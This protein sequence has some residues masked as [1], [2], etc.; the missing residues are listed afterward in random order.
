MYPFQ[1]IILP[2]DFSKRCEAIVPAVRAM[3]AKSGANITLFHALDMPPGGY[4]DWYSYA[5][6]VDLQ[7][8]I[9]HTTHSL[10]RFAKRLFEGVPNVETV[11]REGAP[12]AAL[13]IYLKD[14]PADLVMIASHGH[15]AFR[16]MLLGS[17]TS[18]ILHD[19][20]LPVW[21]A[22]HA[23]EDPALHG[24]RNVVCAIDLEPASVKV[25][26]MATR[27]AQDSGATLHVVHSE[28]A[29]EDLTHSDS[30]AR[31]R[32]F[33]EFRAGEDY[34]PLASEAGISA[35]I[36]VVEGPV[37]ESIAGAVTKHNADLLV[38]GRGVVQ[39]TLGRLRSHSNDI[40]RRS[41]CPVLSV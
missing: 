21:T 2:V 3:A 20:N 1:R 9:D 22:A 29:I 5:A 8:V 24:I 35:P 26:M 27:V 19:L 31:F 4:A 11:V 30:A 41:P 6:L 34:A 32:R 7:A 33:L 14:H 13:S 40:I 10:E 15:G 12:V 25:L 37:G 38:I 16:A 39:G 23:I 36:E 28:P 17:V 18:G